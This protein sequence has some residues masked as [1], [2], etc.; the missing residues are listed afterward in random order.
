[1]HK[2]QLISKFDDQSAKV[3]ILGLGYVGL[4]L[5]VVLAEAGYQ[6]VGIDPDLSKIQLL[7]K[8]QNYID[9]VD[10]E[11]LKDLVKNGK[12]S[13]TSDFSAVADA[14]A[15]S[16]CVP[17]PLRKTRDPDLSYVMSVS[18]DIAPYRKGFFPGFLTRAGRPGQGGLDDP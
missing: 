6:V 14:D 4:P 3:A 10:S 5:A 17:T 13:A 15:V 16:I 2:D 11:L 18:R 12:F 8:G 1:M 7:E 9:D